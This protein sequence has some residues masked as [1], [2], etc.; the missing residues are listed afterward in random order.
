MKLFEKKGGRFFGT[1]RTSE[2]NFLADNVFFFIFW[3]FIFDWCVRLSWLHQLFNCTLN[4]HILLTY[5]LDGWY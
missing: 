1:Q 5:L 3:P 2:N 4:I